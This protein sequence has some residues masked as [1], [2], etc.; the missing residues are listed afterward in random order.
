MSFPNDLVYKRRLLCAAGCVRHERL[1]GFVRHTPLAVCVLHS[2]LAGCVLHT[3]NIVRLWL[4]FAGNG[5]VP[6]QQQR[7]P[8][9]AP[10][11]YSQQQ[12]ASRHRGPAYP[13]GAPGAPGPPGAQYP[14]NHNQQQL[15]YPSTNANMPTHGSWPLAQQQPSADLPRLPMPG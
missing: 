10:T 6:Y 9:Q 11:H 4:M 8:G 5:M 15:G 12:G 2:L 14:P 3:A 1:A 7:M 13:G